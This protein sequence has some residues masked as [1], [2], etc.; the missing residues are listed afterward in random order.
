MIINT[1]IAA[2][3]SATNLANSTS[4]LNK[5]LSELSSGSKITSASDDPAGLAESIG[6]TADMNRDA[7]AASNVTNAI[8]FSQTQDGTLQNIGSALDQMSSLAVEAQDVTKSTADKTDYQA[9]FATLQAYISSA[10]GQQFNGV[11]LFSAT[12]VSVTTDGDGGAFTMAGI[13]LSATA[14]TNATSNTLNITTSTGATA[15]LTK[16]EAAITQLSTDRATVG[17]NEARLNTNSSELSVLQNNLSAASSAITDV[18]VATES[19]E[20]AKYQILVQA[21]TS[22]LAQANQDP[23]SVLKLLS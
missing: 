21:G 14:Y 12:S 18:D 22:M 7:A 13:N 15:A 9:E 8:S 6:L 4:S 11:T 3:T 10:T 17:A 2:E 5:A 23:Q 1:N 16:V 20:F 19:T